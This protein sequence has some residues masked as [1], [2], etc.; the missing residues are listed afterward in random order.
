LTVL[1][2]QSKNEAQ[3]NVAQLLKM[4][5]LPENFAERLPGQLSGGEKQR[6]AIARAFAANPELVVCDEPVSA[7]DVSVQAAIL[8]LLNELQHEK[9]S[10]Y[11]FI[12]HDL[13][14]VSYLADEIAVIYLGQLVEIGKTED[15]L[16]PPFHPYTE[17]L[18]SAVPQP[19]PTAY[20]DTIRLEGDVPSPTDIPTGCR[21][22]TRCPLVLESLC[23]RE[24]PSWQET[25]SGKKIRC[26]IPL[27]ELKVL[28]GV[29]T[30][31]I[32]NEMKGGKN[33]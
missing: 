25:E 5:R 11:L 3:E 7:L 32:F 14:V 2:G 4:V 10:A 31:K 6:V 28:Q 30:V 18:L 16:K 26:H 24:E 15:V 20:Q 21:F 23:H 9:Q 22:H 12:S 19:D 33:G 13:A 1:L 8:N 17:A 27:P 29:N